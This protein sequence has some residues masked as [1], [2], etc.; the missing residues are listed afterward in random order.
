MVNCIFLLVVIAAFTS[1]SESAWVVASTKSTTSRRRQH[2]KFSIPQSIR[3]ASSSGVA[4][5]FGCKE[6]WEKQYGNS[7]QDFSWYASWNDLEPFLQD[8]GVLPDAS[9]N[10]NNSILIPG[11]GN[12]AALLRDM[13]HAGYH[14]SSISAFDYA[15]ESEQYLRQSAAEVPPSIQLA[16]AD[17]RDLSSCYRTAQFDAVLDK[18]TLDAV[19]LAGDSAQ[20]RTDNLRRAVLEL[21][22]VLKPSGGLFF[23]LAGIVPPDIVLEYFDKE[24]W[25]CLTDGSS[26]YITE[27]GY[28]SNNL[29]GTLR[30]WRKK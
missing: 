10:H 26:L 24:H 6:Y 21:Q 30:A 8:F 2:D 14:Q 13:H 3:L 12:D 11:I 27:S 22:R 7:T 25:D 4:Q 28:T 20:E 9:G 19:Y 18:G 29:D 1:K 16:T 15:A 17:V 5:P 23:S